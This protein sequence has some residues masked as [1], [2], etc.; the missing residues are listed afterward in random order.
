MTNTR[1]FEVSRPILL[2]D[3]FEVLKTISEEMDFHLTP[4]GLSVRSMDP[5]HEEM[6]E[7][8]LPREYF[9]IWN[10]AHPATITFSLNEAFKLLKK[11]SK[12]DCLTVSMNDKQDK[13]TFTMRSDIIRHKT[14]S[15]LEP[16]EEEP[17]KPKIY[18]TS[19]TR[20]L[21]STFRRVIRDF[22]DSAYTTF[23]ATSDYI[24]FSTVNDDFKESTPINKDNDS[25]LDHRVE[26]SAKSV[27]EVESLLK[28]LSKAVKVSEVV[29]IHLREDMPIK[30]DIEL[31]QGSMIYY[32]APCMGI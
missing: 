3:Y 7:F 23:E 5:S 29:N 17:P 24:T 6:I 21:L 12:D 8:S 13:L 22:K 27:F 14:I 4:E 32:R 16:L 25:V 30:L 31:P 15:L 18:F 2:R 20:I 1:L 26:D 28:F 11:L 19:I 10:I 9:D